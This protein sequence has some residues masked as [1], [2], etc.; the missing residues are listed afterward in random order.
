MIAAAKSTQGPGVIY[1]CI[2]DPPL[3][4]DKSEIENATCAE[5]N[6]IGP[7]KMTKS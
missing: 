7:K 2:S 3:S 6:G 4:E 5:V 1:P